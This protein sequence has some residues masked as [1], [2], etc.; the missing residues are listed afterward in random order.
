[1]NKKEFTE[2]LQEGLELKMFKVF[3]VE[4]GISFKKDNREILFSVSRY[5]GEYILPPSI[6][7][8]L[9]VPEVEDVLEKYFVNHK[10]N[11]SRVTV[12]R[13]SS[14]FE[15]IDLRSIKSAESFEKVGGVYKGLLNEIKSF[16]TDFDSI[17]KIETEIKS[18]NEEELSGFI[19]SPIHPR[20]MVLK[21]LANASDWESFC[22]R[23]IDIYKTQ[24]EGRY[25]AVFAPVYAFLPSL[26][27][28]LKALHN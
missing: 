15:D 28:E 22:E 12:Y 1:M 9:C 17:E 5:P 24:L 19:F 14:R 25:K 18:F 23:S 7:G 10:L 8:N 3:H 26:Y 27:K 16:Y 21:R 2:L 4:G 11:Y 20:I 13:Q 6:I